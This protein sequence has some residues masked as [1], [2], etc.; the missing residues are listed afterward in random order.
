MAEQQISEFPDDISL[1]T[2]NTAQA[3]FGDAFQVMGGPTPGP[4]P[5]QLYNTTTT[6]AEQP[7]AGGVGLSLLSAPKQSRKLLFD[8][9]KLT[10]DELREELKLRNLPTSGTRAT[11]SQRL[12]AAIEENPSISL[13]R[14]N[15]QQPK[16]RKRN[17]NKREPFRAEFASEELYEEAWHKW[18][19]TRDNNNESVK[20]S[21]ENA[22]VKRGDHERQCEERE[23]ENEQ[24]T[25]QVSMLRQQVNC[26]NKVLEAPESL[27]LDEQQVVRQL[28]DPVEGIG[29]VLESRP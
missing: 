10:V 27:T 18:R 11:L 9:E 26:L 3:F 7:I 20:R 14:M 28:L 13:E 8:H 2:P 4:A 15:T 12:M 25:V 5:T 17:N 22:K 24:L 6:T 1:L 16:K 29:A 21:R 23:R 19:D